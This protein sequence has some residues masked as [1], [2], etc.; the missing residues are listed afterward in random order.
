VGK[1]SNL[2]DG[3]GT[4]VRG[5]ATPPAT[6]ALEPER[7]SLLKAAAEWQLTMPS[8]RRPDRAIGAL[9]SS[10]EAEGYPHPVCGFDR[11][12]LTQPCLSEQ[13]REPCSSEQPRGLKRRR[14]RQGR[15]EDPG[16]GLANQRGGATAAL[17]F[18]VWCLAFGAIAAVRSRVS[19]RQAGGGL[20][21]KRQLFVVD[22]ARRVRSNWVSADREPEAALLTL[23]VGERPVPRFIIDC[24][25]P[26]WDH[27]L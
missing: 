25:E 27:L 22:E 5:G 13:P 9:T 14:L 3:G 21:R 20:A 8:T 23:E 26:Q 18:L 4:H 10:V 2:V 6:V 12:R 1:A 15:G 11:G 24:L 16:R 19:S 7:I 17:S